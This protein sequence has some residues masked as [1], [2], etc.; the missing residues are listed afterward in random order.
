MF[1]HFLPVA[2]LVL[3][4]T[5]TMHGAEVRITDHDQRFRTKYGI[6]PPHIQRSI[7]YEKQVAERARRSES[8]RTAEKQKTRQ[9]ESPQEQQSAQ[10]QK[11]RPCNCERKGN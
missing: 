6:W 11:D 9:V 3:T 2:V 10:D 8:G 1:V 5:A 4:A 7:D